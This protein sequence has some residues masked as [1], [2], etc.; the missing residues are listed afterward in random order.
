MSGL[1]SACLHDPLAIE[2]KYHLVVVAVTAA[3]ACSGK[4]VASSFM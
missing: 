1:S 4:A 2:P 3:T